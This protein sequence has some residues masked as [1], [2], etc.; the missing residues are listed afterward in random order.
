MLATTKSRIYGD[1]KEPLVRSRLI[2]FLE[3]KGVQEI[4]G[5]TLE[6]CYTFELFRVAN[7]WKGN[8]PGP[9]RE[10]R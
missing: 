6:D 2:K 8:E 4:E 3:T 7:S 9:Y 1:L 5:K 10:S